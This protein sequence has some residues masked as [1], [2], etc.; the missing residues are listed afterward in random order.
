MTGIEKLLYVSRIRDIYISAQPSAT[1]YKCYII[2]FLDRDSGKKYS[3]IIDTQLA[4]ETGLPIDHY[5][6]ML[7]D[8]ALRQFDGEGKLDEI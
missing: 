2:T 8:D 1:M 3:G 4:K 5:F 6:E 7:L